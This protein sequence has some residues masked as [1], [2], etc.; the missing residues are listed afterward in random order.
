MVEELRQLAREEA[1][2]SNRKD[3]AKRP[4]RFSAGLAVKNERGSAEAKLIEEETYVAPERRRRPT[5]GEE[6]ERE[7][8]TRRRTDAEDERQKKLK[9]IFEK[10]GQARGSSGGT[11]SR[12]IEGPDTM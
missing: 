4:P 12:D 1:T 10:Y 9:D 8:A 5:F 3:Y 11:Q 6:E 7:R 2:C